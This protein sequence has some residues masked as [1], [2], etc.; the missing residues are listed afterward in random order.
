MSSIT[1]IIVLAIILAVVVLIQQWSMYRASKAVIKIFREKEAVGARNAKSIE[2]LRLQPKS[3][4]R[5]LMGTRDYKPSALQGLIQIGIVMQRDDGKV[6]LS[7]K[8][9]AATRF[10]GN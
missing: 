9:L 5:R 8:N 7:E 2:E 6:Y 3:F 10:K 4:Y 1:W